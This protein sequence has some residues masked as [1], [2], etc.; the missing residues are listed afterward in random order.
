[1]FFFFLNIYHI[2]NYQGASCALHYKA[3]LHIINE[4]VDINNGFCSNH[5]YFVRSVVAQW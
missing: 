5:S 3:I 4:I 2:N 1:M